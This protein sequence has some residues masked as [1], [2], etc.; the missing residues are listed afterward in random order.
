MDRRAQW[1][2]ACEVCLRQPGH[3]PSLLLLSG[4]IESSV[5]CVGHH[6]WDLQVS[7]PTRAGSCAPVDLPV[8]STYVATVYLLSML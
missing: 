6:P 2:H 3:R 8:P 5:L 7:P 1:E 4:Q